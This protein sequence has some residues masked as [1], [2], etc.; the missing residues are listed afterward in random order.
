MRR[1]RA[2]VRVVPPDPVYGE[3]LVTKMVNKIMWDGLFI[4]D[5]G[6]V[7]AS[8]KQSGQEKS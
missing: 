7:A 1:R 4:N 6:I 8:R 2:E 3:V 5:P